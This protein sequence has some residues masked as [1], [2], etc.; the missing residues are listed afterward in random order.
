MHRYT[1]LIR[2]WRR[3]CV[4]A[5]RFMALLYL[6]VD[7]SAVAGTSEPQMG[8][9]ALHLPQGLSVLNPEI[10]VHGYNF[11]M[12][13]NPIAQVVGDYGSEEILYNAM[14]PSSR[15]KPTSTA[16]IIN[17]T[18]Q[19]EIA[20]FKPYRDNFNYTTYW[21][22]WGVAYTSTNF[23]HA[24]GSVGNA[25]EAG[26]SIQLDCQGGL[27]SIVDF[28]NRFP[29]P[30]GQYWDM[31][32][33]QSYSSI[34][35]SCL[36]SDASVCHEHC[37]P[38]V[39]SDDGLT[40]YGFDYRYSD[41][42]VWQ[43]T[44]SNQTFSTYPI[45]YPHQGT[46]YILGV[47]EDKSKLLY[48]A[49]SRINYQPSTFLLSLKSNTSSE[50]SHLP[51]TYGIDFSNRSVV[52]AEQDGA[53]V[54]LPLSKIETDLRGVPFSANT[55]SDFENNDWQIMPV[56]QLSSEALAG[57]PIKRHTGPDPEESIDSVIWVPIDP[58]HKSGVLVNALDYWQDH[59]QI[60]GIEHWTLDNHLNS[61]YQAKKQ[62][63][64]MVSYYGYYR[65]RDNPEQESVLY[66][67]TVDH[68]HCAPVSPATT[69]TTAPTS[70]HST[71][72][73]E[74]IGLIAGASGA[75]AVVA[76]GIVAVVALLVYCKIKGKKV[77][78]PLLPHDEDIPRGEGYQS[79][80]G[81]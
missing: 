32:G 58:V 41:F 47:S 7:I 13:Y 31:R 53:V 45:S 34:A 23:Q 75:G 74:R 21:V 10:C 68:S 57:Y 29:F 48:R 36:N 63:N 24:I 54:K 81:T 4:R 5:L 62:S 39:I 28:L 38:H 65:R 46:P 1:H 42:I 76:V 64:G 69:V 66:R 12:T 20:Q 6:A 77:P 50:L 43:R 30:Q 49:A 16:T 35:L 15:H 44:P 27:N 9:T 17:S 14:V 2:S 79:I 56:Q 80:K 60:E 37:V 40:I 72:P 11:S 26:K 70:T 78:V 73:S 71:S 33:G 19:Q 67:I 8:F 52:V 59:C 55:F 61:I 25:F 51:N 3:A 18:N 22:P